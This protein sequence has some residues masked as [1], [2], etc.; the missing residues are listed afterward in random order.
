MSSKNAKTVVIASLTHTSI[1]PSASSTASAAASTASWSA[2]ST[3]SFRA[4]PP[5]ASAALLARRRGGRF[6]LAPVNPFETRRRYVPE[7]NVLETTFTTGD[8]AVRVTDALTLDG[9][10]PTPYTELVRRIDGVAGRCEVAW[11]L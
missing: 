8:G 6:A 7:S 4:C 5:S 9:E 1:G 11:H 3:G 10:S 2:T